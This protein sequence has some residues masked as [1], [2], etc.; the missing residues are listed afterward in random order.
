MK[1][2][3]AKYV[4]DGNT[5]YIEIEARCKTNAKR[6]FKEWNNQNENKCTLLR[7]K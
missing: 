3:K 6:K 5:L 4:R 7:I 2:F 1:T